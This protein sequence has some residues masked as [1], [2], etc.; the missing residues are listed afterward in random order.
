MKENGIRYAVQTYD[1][2]DPTSDDV[3]L[4]YRTYR[5]IGPA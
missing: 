5:E 4:G 2:T 3:E 1:T